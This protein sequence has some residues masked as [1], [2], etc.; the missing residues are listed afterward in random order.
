MDEKLQREHQIR[1]LLNELLSLSLKD[2]SLD[3]LLDEAIEQITSIPKLVFE[4]RGAIF[5]MDE[6]TNTLVLKAHRGL[7][8]SLLEQCATLSLDTCL[9]GRAAATKELVF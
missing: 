9:C 2:L 5:L 8:P 3:V 4:T 7:H 1:S 6:E